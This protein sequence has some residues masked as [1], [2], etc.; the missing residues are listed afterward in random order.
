VV[1]NAL[2]TEL[3]YSDGSSYGEHMNPDYILG[4]S[5][6]ALDDRLLISFDQHSDT[7]FGRTQLGAEYWW[8]NMVAFRV[9]V[10]EG[11]LTVGVGFRY[12]MFQVDYA[13]R[14]QEQPLGNQAFVSVTFGDATKM[15]LNRPE[16]ELV[17]ETDQE[18]PA[19]KPEPIKLTEPKPV[20]VVKERKATPPPAPTAQPGLNK[21]TGIQIIDN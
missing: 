14:Y 21:E 3:K 7:K 1:K 6:L 2:Q 11:D 15:F 9:G 13:V 20:P 17:E 5:W 16:I 4:V 8:A 19:E 12:A 18:E 10:A